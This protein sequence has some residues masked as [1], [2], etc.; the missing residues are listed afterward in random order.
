MNCNEP[1][2]TQNWTNLVWLVIFQIIQNPWRIRRSCNYKSC[3][4]LH[5]LSPQIFWEFSHSL[6]IFPW[7]NLSFGVYFAFENN[8]SRAHLSL[9]DSSVGPAYRVAS[10]TWP[11]HVI[12]S[13]SIHEIKLLSCHHRRRPPPP[14]TPPLFSPMSAAPTLLYFPP[15]TAT[16]RPDAFPPQWAGPRPLPQCG[17]ACSTELWAA[18]PPEPIDTFMFCHPK[19]HR[20]RQPSSIGSPNPWPL[21]RV[22]RLILSL[23]V[24]SVQ[25]LVTSNGEANGLPQPRS[26]QAPW[27]RPTS[28]AGHV[29]PQVH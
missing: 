26:E 20:C 16:A 14:P 9:A 25:H 18:P 22:P 4:K 27:P 28:W 24:L 17:E 23:V 2:W 29:S 21:K 15:P 6:A 13:I 12:A 3:S 8:R 5:I 10:P 7:W 11:P 1:I 19:D